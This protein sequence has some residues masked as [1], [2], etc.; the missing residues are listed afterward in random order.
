MQKITILL[1][2]LGLWLTS[3]LNAELQMLLG[4]SLIFSFGILHGANDLQLINQIEAVKKVKFLKVLGVYV[5]LVLLS[6]VLFI[7]IPVFALTLFILVSAYH[8]GEQ[9]WQNILKDSNKVFSGLIQGIYGLLILAAIF[10]FN[11]EEVEK[12]IYKITNITINEAEFLSLFLIAIFFY[13]I[14]AITLI[15]RNKE[16]LPH[17]IEQSFYILILCVIFKVAS[18][19]LGFAIYFILWHSIPSLHD[20]VKFLYGSYNFENFKKYFK[21]AFWYWIISLI[22]V[23]ILYFISKDM[24]IFDALFLSFLASITFPHFIVIVQMYKK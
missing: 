3:Y 13:I 15:I 14:A 16:L 2:F 9:N 20:Q 7:H 5:I 12:V 6:V 19:I 1:S 17:V 10:Y 8:F 18:L 24:V 21:S 22:G 4:L 11:V 23:F